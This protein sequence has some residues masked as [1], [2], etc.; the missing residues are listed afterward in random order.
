MKR[1]VR[2]NQEYKDLTIIV[3]T[4]KEYKDVIDNISSTKEIIQTEEDQEFKEITKLELEDFLERKVQLD[5]KIKWLLIPKDPD[6]NKNVI[7]EIRAGMGDEACIFVE[8]IFRIS[9][10]CILKK[11]LGPMM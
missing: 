4:Y 7:M 5:D 1:Y 3:N 9:L 6:D 10:L 11:S 2:L 8:D